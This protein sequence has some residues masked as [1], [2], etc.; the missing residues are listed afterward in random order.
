MPR[1]KQTGKGAYDKTVNFITRNRNPLYSG[2]QHTILYTKDGFK[3]ASYMGPKTQLLK[4]LKSGSKPVSESDKISMIHDI[5][6]TLSKNAD[7]V[8]KANLK[9]LETLDRTAKNKADY[10]YN[11][12]LAKGGIKAKVVLEDKFK[13][14]RTFFT[15]FGGDYPEEDRKIMEDTLKEYEQLGYGKKKS[16]WLTHVAKY[17]AKHPDKSYKQCLIEAKKS[18]KK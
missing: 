15:T 2:E 8:R 4:R 9:M 3:P 6:Y 18:Y 10:R 17:R 13:V 12:A 14:P 1:K 5:R 7:D 16:P 11:I